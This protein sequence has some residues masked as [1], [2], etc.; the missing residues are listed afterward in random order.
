MSKRQTLLTVTFLAGLLAT[1]G[2]NTLQNLNIE[3]PEYM[4]RDVRPRVSVALPLSASTIDFDMLVEVR[5]PN[6]VS[7]SLD[8]IDFDLFVDDQRIFDGQTL[9]RVRIPANGT[10]DVRIRAEVGY[11][12]IR[13]LFREVAD[14]IQG[15]RAKYEL[16]GRAYYDTPLGRLNFPFSVYRQ[17]L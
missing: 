5:N 6:R 12:D 4:L 14:A 10:G 11:E 7:L 9:D 2:C 16:R 13:S 8:R 15:D 3:N 1:S 17:R